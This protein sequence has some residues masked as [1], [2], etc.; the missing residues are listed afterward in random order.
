MGVAKADYQKSPKNS[1]YVRA[2][3][4]NLEAPS[5]YDGKNALTLNTNAQHNRVYSLAVGDTYLISAN[6]INSFH[7]GVNRSEIIKITD[8]FATW[9][10]LGVNA[11]YNPAPAPRI[12]V[13]GGNG[14]N[15]GGG[16]SIIN[17]DAGGPN[18]S[19][20]DDVSWVKGSHQI[21]F[22]GSYVH[23]LLNYSSGINATGLMTFN[24]TVTGL[25][26]S[27]FLLGQAVTWAQGN[28]QSYLYNRQQYLALYLQDSWKATPRLTVNYGVRWEPFFAFT[29]KHGWFDHFDPGLFAQNIHS[30]VYPNAPAGLIFPGDPQWTAG[31]HSI[32]SNRYG[33]FLP[34]LGLVWDPKGDG[35][36]SIRASVGMFTDRGALYSMSAMAQDTP[37]GTVV[38]IP[39]VNMSNPWANYP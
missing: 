38:S 15:I 25:G 35:K 27:D 21:G 13:S 17:V 6:I 37:Y 28:L 30:T 14:F 12:A 24:G 23:T 19:I 1:M 32:A 20:N 10:Q 4:T 9:P 8:D 7:A 3:V 39:N 34:R 11:P 5:T 31:D 2:F 18:P 29:N 22:G 36:M 33:V 16:N 26:L